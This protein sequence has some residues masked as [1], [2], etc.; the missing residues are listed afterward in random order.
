M[1]ASRSAS[2]SPLTLP[3]VALVAGC[4]ALGPAEPAAW[5]D[6]VATFAGEPFESRDYPAGTTKVSVSVN[7]PNSIEGG[8]GRFAR[9][10]SAQGGTSGQVQHLARSNA[11]AGTFH[12]GL[13]AKSNAEQ[14]SGLSFVAVSAVGC[15]VKQG[16]S[17][18]AVMVSAPGR[19]GD[20]EVKDGKVLSRLTRAFFTGDQAVAFGAAYR[21]REDER[22]RQASARLKER[23]TQKLAHM[24][25]L[26]SNPRVGD[27]TSVGTI[28]EV[29]PPLV[30]V[31]YDERYRSLANRSATEWLPIASL[32]PESR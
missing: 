23:E 19:P 2:L 17:L 22:S 3:T 10:C 4:A 11:T 27:R 20:T 9:W 12:D 24:Q 7:A 13:A 15:L 21:Q 32:M 30:L 1:K 28:V 31:Q 26:R 6:F 25:R 16:Q 18:L 8:N 29:R 14:A 5:Q